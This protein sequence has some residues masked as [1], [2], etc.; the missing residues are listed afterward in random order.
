VRVVGVLAHLVVPNN[1]LHSIQ[2]LVS[3]KEAVTRDTLSPESK[4][5]LTIIPFDFL[6]RL[7]TVLYSNFSP[8]ICT[9]AQI[10]RNLNS[11]ISDDNLSH[12]GLTLSWRAGFAEGEWPGWQV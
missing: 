6:N 7:S 11:I 4:F 12:M 8:E 1:V 10:V 3:F 9:V 2:Y 5:I